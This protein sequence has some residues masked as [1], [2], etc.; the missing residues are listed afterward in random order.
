MKGFIFV[1]HQL[2]RNKQFAVILRKT[3]FYNVGIT[4]RQRLFFHAD[5]LNERLFRNAGH[6]VFGQSHDLHGINVT[7]IAVGLYLLYIVPVK[8]TG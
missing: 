6:F 4:R 5:Q 8:V 7:H 1:L 2:R 3:A